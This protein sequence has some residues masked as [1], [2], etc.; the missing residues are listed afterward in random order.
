M[1]DLQRAAA[2]APGAATL[3]GDISY[4]QICK[5]HTSD[6]NIVMCHRSINYMAEMMETKYGIPWIKVN[7]IGGSSSTKS[8]RK[9]ARYFDSKKLTDRVEEVIAQEMLALK[10]VREEIK[11]RHQGKNGYVTQIGNDL[12]AW[13]SSGFSKSRINFLE[14]LQPERITYCLNDAARDYW[15]QQRLPKEP[16]QGL[17]S[18]PVVEII[19]TKDWEQH[20]NGLGIGQK[21]HRRIA[22]EGALLGGFLKNQSSLDLAIV[23]DGAGQFALLNHGLCW[24]HAERLV[25]KLIPLNDPQRLDHE[26]VRGEI[27]SL[28]RDLKAYKRAPNPALATEYE[29]R[30]DA[31]FTQ[32]TS[33]ETLNQTLKRLHKRKAELLLVLK[34]PD[35]PLHTNGSETD[36]RDFV[37]KSKISGGTRS[38]LGRTCRDTFA[39]LKKTCRKLGLSFWDYVFDRIHHNEALLPLP[40]ILR[41]RALAASPVP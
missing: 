25:H 10:P 12:F 16:R 2:G 14:L 23:S 4:E 8:L 31:L 29:A 18:S 32:Q 30:F 28:Y 34:R 13:F 22:T 7:F 15:Q 38:D 35:I 19:G 33:F 20:L 37:K 1:A 26:R 6:L 41:Q 11:A 40:D 5:C 36:I 17:E 27:W 3:S 9:I 24:V 21:R 39:S